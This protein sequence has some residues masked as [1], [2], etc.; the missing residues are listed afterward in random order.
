MR[1]I[2]IDI[3][4]TSV[5]VA[6]LDANGTIAHTDYALH[7]G[8]AVASLG[9]LIQRVLGLPGA[10]GIAHGAVT[11]SGGSLLS[12]AGAARRVNE[13]AAL[14]E[15]VLR[16][17]DASASIIEMGGQTAKF[18]TGF[19]P[20]DKSG[21]QVSMT[22]NCS[23]G[24]GSFLE[25]QVSRLGLAIED[26]SAL[27]SRA[28]TIPRIAGRC[29]VF[30]KTDITHHQQEGVPVAD[31]L[32]GLAHAVVKNY[33]S[34]VMRGLP[35]VPPLFFAGGVSLNRA[36]ESA[37]RAVLGLDKEELRLHEH[38]SVAG[39]VGAAMLAADQALPLDL[40][41]VAA[42]PA[43][44]APGNLYTRETARLAP[45]RG[46]G[47]GRDKHHC[48]VLP[49]DFRAAAWLG[50]DVGSTSTN[51]VLAD[52]DDR[53]L[54]YRYLRTAGDPAEAVRTGLAQ[55][56]R[57]LGRR[58]RVAGVGVTGSGRYMI[59]R[60]AG[61]DLVRDEITAQ[62]RAAVAIDPS[63]DTVFEIGGQDSKF[64]AIEDGVVTD[65]QMNKI[66]AAGTGSFIEEQCKRL[67]VRLDRIGPTALSATS[68]VSLGE[69]CTVFM[70]SG[71]AAHMARGADAADLAAGLCY[72]IVKNY[73]NRVVGQKR[74]GNSIFLQGGV[75][76]NQGVVNAF[77]SVTGRKVAV[78]PFFSV[79]GA[80]GA[81]I[82]AREEM[83][84]AGDAATRFRGFAPEPPTGAETESRP[85]TAIASDFNRQVQAFIFEDY[86]GSL[87]PDKKTVGI[88]RALFT[89]GMFPLF[90]PFFRELG[91]NVL[92]SGP[93]SEE[94]IRLAQEYSLDETCYP[95]KLIN[96]HAAEL[97]GKGVDYLF[98]PDLYTVFH[99]GSQSRQDY[100]CAY[101]QLAFKIVN[102]A[103]DLDGKGIRLLAPT[104]AFNQGPEFMQGVFMNMG[105]ELER[106]E[107]ETGKALQAAMASL[108]AF[109][110]RVKQRSRETITGL[111]PD[112]KTF[113]LISKIYGVA[114]PVLNLG[115][116]DK[117]A[118][119]GY[120][121]LPFYDMPE[122]DIFGEHPNMY[123]PF[124]QHILE[125]AKLV[126]KHPNL[127]AVFLTHHGCGPDTVTAHYFKEIMGDKPYLTIEV[128]EHSS[129]VGVITRVEAFVNSLGKRPV[130]QAGPLETY[131]EMEPDAPVDITSEPTLAAAGRVIVPRL[132]PYS[133][134]ACSALKAEGIDAVETDA[135]TA[136]SIDLGR[137]H[138]VTNEYYSLAVLLGDL[139]HTLKA[140]G[141]A[142]A[143]T[144]LLLPQNEGAE[145]DGQYARF[146]RTKLNEGGLAHV[147]IASPFM[148][149]LP[150]LDAAQ[151]RVMCLCLLA[152]DIVLLA[153][154]DRRETLMETLDDAIRG[155]ALTLEF[156]TSVAGQ[157]RAWLRERTG[158]KTIFAL[159]EPM[160]L[161][162][163]ILNDNTFKKLEDS[164][165]RVLYAPFSECMWTFWHDFA[166]TGNGGREHKKRLLDEFRETIRAIAAALGEHGHFERDPEHLMA[167]ADTSLG[168]Y[169]GAFGRYRSAKPAGNLSGANGV[170]AVASMY[171]NTG[172]SLDILQKRPDGNGSLPMLTLTFDGN[173]NK[174]D[175]T[176]V[177]S[178]LFYI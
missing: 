78:P 93:T 71:I 166:P 143:K 154:R 13:V 42:F 106:T 127:Y 1:S 2:G 107:Q 41:A 79:T 47:D 130:L 135:T 10:Q 82:L 6:V 109:E 110:G 25:E 52:A 14:V 141:N 100:G 160:V 9:R 178:F 21:V 62:A 54:A 96:G 61:A 68:P 150:G 173:R 88:P 137:N 175:E 46:D 117:L 51:L 140:A 91:F 145:V 17:D 18:I 136:A 123:W 77:R 74:I 34:A 129:G 114:D 33:R 94:T 49:A 76:H 159:G 80:Y 65:F 124:G 28:A 163:D 44:E 139:L 90:A 40:K 169:A 133:K 167:R 23:S 45:L 7:K 161:Y 70:E 87:D 138:T 120:R 59:G 168:F 64:I 24:T 98:F 53:I 116:P 26:Y 37:M 67:D 39:A 48:P 86:D 170:I 31:I 30:A 144:T 97:V 142:A 131:T 108:K 125:A 155:K 147:G 75:A 102:K 101:M 27:A 55:L 177:E 118:A 89:Y 12:D 164:G 22:S 85:D 157:V 29:S 69:R 115:I 60:M 171:E 121:T 73:L 36:M 4:Y 56:D 126:A 57:E 112:R 84:S 104:I 156:L 3:G 99:P 172:I 152:G 176:K 158:G 81:A 105:R 111:D 146:V 128:D 72:S 122:T 162:N 83:E 66:C 50:I 134:L 63:V 103:M 5:K 119:M 35:R 132:R 95:V 20:E 15:G 153:P 165:H 32:A 16:L 149:D 151:A 92:L 19:S 58:V 8:Q 113:V 148:E 174:T 38:A 11:G 43:R